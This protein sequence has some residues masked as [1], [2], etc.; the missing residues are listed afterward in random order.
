[1]TEPSS[2][3]DLLLSLPLFQGIS[4]FDISDIIGHTRFS[5]FSREPGEMVAE[6]GD[7]CS[8]LLFLT[9]GL[10]RSKAVS[11]S[12]TY[13][14]FEDIR[15]IQLLQA[16]HLFGLQPHYSLTFTAIEH[17]NLIGIGKQDVMR[18]MDLSAIIRINMLNML[19][20]RC[21][22]LERNLWYLPGGDTARRI[23]RFVVMRSLYPA[24]R[25]EIKIKMNTLAEEINDSRLDVSQALH[26]LQDRGLLKMSRGRIEIP[27]L[28]LLL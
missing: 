12:H 19:S 11:A 17:C 13:E 3:F 2:S 24:G 28:E 15:P 18:L 25:K 20:A 5:F 27:K 4:R 22:K 23:V 21:Q 14:F 8:S 7:V 16:D 10:L 6:E 1:M 9:K 26:G